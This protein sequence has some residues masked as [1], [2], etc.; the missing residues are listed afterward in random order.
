[1]KKIPLYLNELPHE[2][3]ATFYEYLK[4]AKAVADNTANKM[5][6]NAM[7]TVFNPCFAPY[8]V[9]DLG[10]ISE[11]ETNAAVIQDEEKK[12]NIA[13]IKGFACMISN[14]NTKLTFNDCRF[15]FV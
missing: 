14:V 2:N 1:M 10:L 9:R 11:T 3:R 4:I 15:Q 8:T 6:V 12:K 7:A 5:D 13:L